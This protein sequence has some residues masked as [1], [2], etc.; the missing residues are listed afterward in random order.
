[1]VDGQNLTRRQSS[2]SVS[3]AMLVALSYAVWPLLES[4]IFRPQILGRRFEMNAVAIL[5][6]LAFWTWLWGIAGASI[7]VPALV[8]LKI[9]CNRIESLSSLGEFLSSRQTDKES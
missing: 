2:D 5:L 6:F 9:F 8:T 1:M 4:E 3:Y 7:A